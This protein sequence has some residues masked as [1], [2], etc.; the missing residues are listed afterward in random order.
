MRARFGPSGLVVGS[1]ALV[2]LVLTVTRPSPEGLVSFGVGDREVR[3]APGA[4]AATVAV[5]HELRAL[6]VFNRTLVRI[7]DS[8]VDPA[9]IDP[10]KMLYAALDS[11]QYNIPEVLIEARPERDELTIVV[12]DKQERFTTADVDSP[13]RLSSKLKKI[14]GFIEGNM[15]PGA[16]LADI[17]YAA[18]NGMLST[19]DPHSVLLNP[20]MAREMEVSTRAKFG[21]LGIVVGMRD[22]KLTVLRPMPDTPAS[23]AGLKANDH[24][25]KIDNDLTENLTTDEAV[26]R[27]RGKRGTRVVLM[28]KRAGSDAA[29]RFELERAEISVPSVKWKNLDG[30][31]YIKLTQFSDD[32]TALT[33]QAIKQLTKAGAKGFILDLRG[34]PGG[35]LDE[36]IKVSD[37]FVSDG[38]I[39]TT[40][41]NGER[42]PRRAE[43]SDGDV[44]APVVVLVNENSASASEI[45]AGA[46]KNLDRA[47]IVGSTT[48][49]K[50]SVQILYDNN[51]TS[52]LKLT[53]AQYLAPGDQSIQSIGITP[54]VELERMQVE[55]GG[56]DA[57]R[58]VR[59]LPPSRS[60]R[61]RDLKQHL[62]SSYAKEGPRP[63][64]SLSYLYTRPGR[65][66][67]S[68][69]ANPEI[70]EEEELDADEIVVDF[71]ITLA[72]DLVKAG[73]TTR[74]AQLKHAHK[75]V[76]K[77]RAEEIKK[78][79]DELARLGVDW[80][81]APAGSARPTLEAS[82]GF[83][84]LAAGASVRAGSTLKLTGTVKNTG[85][86]PAYRVHARVQSQ[87]DF[88]DLELP[89][90]RI[91]P[92][93]SRSY[94][95]EL[96][97]RATDL[98]RLSA[99]DFELRD[100][101]G[102]KHRAA[103]AKLRIEATDHPV[104]SYAHQLVDH[105][106]QD[107]LVQP[108]ERY[109]LRVTIKNS[110]KGAATKATATLRNASGVDLSLEKARQ[111]LDAIKPGESK[112]VEF[113]FRTA[114]K[115]PSDKV[116]VELVVYDRELG[117]SVS[118]KLEYPVRKPAAAPAA[119]SG[120]VEA[121]T[122]APIYEGAAV[123]S[124]LIATAARGTVFKV[125]GRQGD[126][127][128]VA[129]DEGRPGFIQAAAV[130]RTSRPPRLT[131]VTPRLQVTPPAIAVEVPSY[132]VTGASYTLRGTATDD[133][134]VE[135]VYVFVSNPSAR[136]DN[137]KVFYKS[138]RNG[139]NGVELPFA[140][141]IPLWPGSNLVT[142]VS[143]ENGNVRAAH[144]LY[145]YRA[146]GVQTAAK[147]P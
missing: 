85:A 58:A 13:W 63:E 142:V 10:K 73:G 118:E 51:D 17:E 49:G 52:K 99:L 140:A 134:H 53:I 54:D 80:S 143:R 72:R 111:K 132:E 62:D 55:P 22:E 45:V 129:L 43:R 30:V 6:K 139:K 136:I 19:L 108:G 91:E 106:N 27:M 8:Y 144:Q 31:G 3:A 74:K 90:G 128:R 16:D 66:E 15:N 28:I 141:T 86:A 133:T 138:N 40:V 81:P 1:A 125:T 4:P 131:G 41:G 26:E 61:E 69:A 39:V 117:D 120:A 29:L 35:L 20:E 11:V 107:G 100:A 137:R 112:V 44:T 57:R 77:R 68:A 110:G 75:V 147:V 79:A 94:T 71:P 97:L 12:N 2:A 9:R 48:F 83:D 34:N 105:G 76:E 32:T 78:V 126:W 47:L 60:Y 5:K 46:L 24:I 42:E 37:L 18:V 65:A 122:E 135:D 121:V 84:G 98:D 21:G 36:A 67:R 95:A 82:F 103:S 50:G 115:I 25:Y 92:G 102:G 114:D 116:V 93:Q 130:K 89:F 7:R 96:T 64:I 124:A 113:A 87:D 70:E 88:N 119:A 104:F 14:F 146:D 33:A 101:T 127:M 38:T 23:R 123:D 109:T 59:L 145:L 56:K